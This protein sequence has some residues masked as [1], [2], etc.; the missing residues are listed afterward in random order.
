[1]L[2]VQTYLASR[3]VLAGVVA[4]SLDSKLVPEVLGVE[5]VEGVE[6]IAAELWVEGLEAGLE[7]ALA[8]AR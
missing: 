6:R 5:E 4:I 7:A 2:A 8:F 1:V 3:Q